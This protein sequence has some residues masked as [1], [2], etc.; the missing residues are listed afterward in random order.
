MI[1]KETFTRNHVDKIKEGKKCDPIILERAIVALGL[2]EA[3][4]KTGCDFIFK[5]G[6]SLM[7]LLDKVSRLS[8]DCDIIVPF[9]FDIDSYIKRASIIY[10][11]KSYNESVRKTNNNIS[12]KH[13][14]F[15]YESIY[16]NKGEVVILLD[17]LFEN[18]SY[19]NILKKEIK[20]NLLICDDNPIYVKCPTIEAI[21]GDKLTAFAPNTTGIK[22][23]NDDFSN[24]KKLEVIKQFFDIVT[25]FRNSNDFDEIKDNYMCMVK[26][27]ISYRNLNI[28]YKES[29]LDTF[30]SALSILSRGKINHNEYLYLLEG[31]RKIKNHIFGYD[32]N[33]ENAIHFAADVMLISSG[34]L[35][36]INVINVKI[37]DKQL[38]NDNTYKNI[39]YVK[40]LSKETF[41]K[42][43]YAISILIEK[44]FIILS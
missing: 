23:Y 22:Y 13:Y 39:N 9:D 30:N 29:L 37:D 3:L 35:S 27:E 26:N 43:S 36:N 21:L 19:K 10:P 12:K 7:I 5:G 20:N 6:S 44:G 18:N 38:F 25:L 40:K 8:T 32:F 16:S 11:F 15:I 4:A 41:N 33:A 17:V 24:D 28:T 31:I 2:V 14:K 1:L 42:A 34:I